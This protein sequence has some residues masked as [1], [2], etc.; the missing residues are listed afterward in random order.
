VH[1]PHMRRAVTACTCAALLGVAC[2]GSSGISPNVIALPADNVAEVSVDYGLPSFPSV[3]GLFTKVTVCVPG[4]TSDCQTVDHVLV[5]TGSSGLRLF[6][7]VLTLSLPA[8]TDDRGVALAEC[9]QFFSGS[10]WGPL[11]TADFSI[12]GEQAATLAIQVVEE[13]TY[14]MPA[15]CTGTDISAPDKL[16]SNGLLG[17]GSSVQD[18]GPPC[19][20]A[21][22]LFSEN[23]KTYYTCSSAAADGCKAAAV[24]V[25]K[26]LSNPVVFFSQ[27]NNGTIVELPAIPEEG[28]PSVM[29]SLV[30]GIGTRENNGLGEATVIRLDASDFLQTK[31]P[32]NGSPVTAFIDSGS[33]VMYVLNS[34]TTHI[35]TCFSAKYPE[36]SAFYCPTSTQNLTARIQDDTGQVGVNVSF[37]IANALSLSGYNFAFDDLAGPSAAPTSGT[38]FASSYF[39]WGL[40]FYFGR[41]VFTSIEGE[42]TTGHAGPFVAF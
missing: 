17:V 6:G 30:F 22:G 8:S 37:S 31:Y 25:A 34:S 24:P 39:D 7:S 41:N 33:N 13:T 16:G 36:V 10:L 5:D 20:A 42:V 14:P 15:G 35:P 4:S 2:S 3:N 38:G 27:D 1:A 21:L 26:Q 28:A 23:P 19:S 29:G 12:A 40:P 11:R 32:T 18:C 9:G